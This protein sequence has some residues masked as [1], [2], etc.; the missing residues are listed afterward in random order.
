MK[1]ILNYSPLPNPAIQRLQDIQHNDIQQN[2]ILQNDI[3]HNTKKLVH[4]A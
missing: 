4:S 2:D 1:V 3:Q